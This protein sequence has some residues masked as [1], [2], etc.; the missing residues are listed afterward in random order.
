MKRECAWPPHEVHLAARQHGEVASGAVEDEARSWCADAGYEFLACRLDDEA[1]GLLA[2]RRLGEQELCS[3][4]GGRGSQ[5][6]VG[7]A[8]TMCAVRINGGPTWG[9]QL[10][11]PNLGESTWGGSTR[12]ANLRCDSGFLCLC[13]LW[14][15]SHIAA[16]VDTPPSS[17]CFPGPP[18]RPG[19]LGPGAIDARFGI[20]AVHSAGFADVRR[21]RRP[22]S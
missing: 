20:L 14:S 10:W 22:E 12:G 21:T 15:R 17:S 18:V 13:R 19:P 6:A 5:C 4:W 16:R 8:S 1:L 9:R 2:A 11:G 7:A 3:R